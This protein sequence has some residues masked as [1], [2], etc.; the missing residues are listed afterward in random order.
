M[1]VTDVSFTDALARLDSIRDRFTD[2]VLDGS[3]S[4]W[5]GSA[6][7]QT[8]FPNLGTLLK[9]L[10]CALYREIEDPTNPLDPA[11]RALTRIFEIADVKSLDVTLRP[12]DHIDTW[13]PPLRD[14]IIGRLWNH[15]SA[16]LAV[17]Y[18]RDV[19]PRS[20]ALDV[21]EVDKLYADPGTLPDAEHR[22]LA[23]LVQ[24]GA[25]R[26]L[27]TTNWDPLI[28]RA[29]RQA[30][31]D[32]AYPD[33]C[34]VVLPRDLAGAGDT[35]PRLTKIHGCAERAQ[36]D[37]DART[38]MVATTG[39]IRDWLTDPDRLAI[40]EAVTT[41]ARDH[42]VLYL[43]LSG[44]DV[45]I[46]LSHVRARLDVTEAQATGEPR[47]LFSAA[48]VGPAQEEVL[49]SSYGP[50]YDGAA[51]DQ[52]DAASVVPLYAKP[53][54]GGLL[55]FVLR[56]KLY[57]FADA[58]P[59][60]AYRTLARQG[61][62]ALV[63]H[64]ATAADAIRDADDRWRFVSKTV[65]RYVSSF[66]RLFATGT[67][68][69]DRWVYHP[70]KAQA[71]PAPGATDRQLA[72]L[73]GILAAGAAQRRW[74]LEFTPDAPEQLRIRTDGGD[75]LPVYIVCDKTMSSNLATFTPKALFYLVL[76]AQ[77][78]SREPVP[79][80]QHLPTASI[81]N[82]AD[83]LALAHSPTLPTPPNARV[84]LYLDDWTEANPHDPVDALHYDL[85]SR[86]LVNGPYDV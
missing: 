58:H 71:R 20:L 67:P 40:R 82:R 64:V 69:G 6:I 9:H 31:D 37:A 14:A 19:A 35:R 54:L 18:R 60:P 21:L 56:E 36:S 73:V 51:H 59:N 70:V 33:I 24:E 45:N 78:N 30:A 52:I 12:V 76:H 63:Q 23:L 8:R 79:S 32:P 11:V 46:L 42:S 26:Q 50:L 44:Q 1:E 15:Y 84:D 5:A 29:H 25:F 55:A 41:T 16:V 81:S 48:R 65:A 66:N 3:V 4:V 77:G 2:R 57:A 62:D 10:F 72:L 75:V 80:R 39:E 83:W 34:V 47:V 49:Q 74:D 86:G 38:Y 7:S 27:L 68:L 22:L 43:G 13:R 17:T 85:W 61:V 28:E 53:L